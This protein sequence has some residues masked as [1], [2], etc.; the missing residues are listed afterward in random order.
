MT[1]EQ[2][3]ARIAD[4]E[5]YVNHTSFGCVREC[6]LDFYEHAEPL[7]VYLT[8]LV[9]AEYYEEPEVW[10]TIP[11]CPCNLRDRFVS[12]E[13]RFREKWRAEACV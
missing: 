3:N 11:E 10:M 2:F 5:S 6:S 8:T 4:I 12:D 7:L 1:D 9:E 13:Q